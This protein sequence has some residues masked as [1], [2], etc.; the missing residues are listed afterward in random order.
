MDNAPGG[1]DEAQRR[2]RPGQ[3]REGRRRGSE[4][5]READ[6]RRDTA[7]GGRR[8]GPPEEVPPR[9]SA[10]LVIPDCP[11]CGKPVRELSSALTHRA[12]RQPAHF[13]CILQEL[14]QSNE[15]AADEKV[16][17][18]GGGC[19]GVLEFRSAPGPNRFVIKRRIQYE[20]KETPQDWKKPL[21]ISC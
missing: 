5:R 8:D 15:I 4:R 18:L 14:R 11:V 3:R 20:E 13:D 6:A 17:Y 10:P 1:R 21:Q 16:C 19:F 9:P 7:G 2:D 12:T